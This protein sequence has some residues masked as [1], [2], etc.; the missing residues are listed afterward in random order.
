MNYM[1]ELAV[2]ALRKTP[3]I[4]DPDGG[5]KLVYLTD[6]INSVIKAMTGNTPDVESHKEVS[7]R[8]MQLE[9]V[10]KHAQSAMLAHVGLCRHW[11]KVAMV[12]TGCDCCP[13]FVAK[14][15]PIR[16]FLAGMNNPKA[17]EHAL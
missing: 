5:D 11:H 8:I 16:M 13:S 3:S 9:S 10:I 7:A 14:T 1:I 12:G 2:D 4:V 15:C 6:A 17:W